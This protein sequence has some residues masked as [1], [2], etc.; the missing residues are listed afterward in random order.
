[1]NI[2][3][4]IIEHKKT[5][6]EFRKSDSPESFLKRESFYSR[7]T[8]SLKS[9]L[10]EGNKWGIIAEFKRK[11]PSKGVINEMADL[12]AVTSAY[13]NHGASGL[14][15]L[16]DEKFFGG[17][18]DDIRKARINSI[19]ILRKDFIIDEYQV[20]ESRAIGADLILLIAACLSPDGV[21]KLAALAKAIG[22]ETLLEIHTKDELSHIC[23]EVDLIGINNRDLKTFA[24]DMN[25]AIELASLVPRNKL[26][27][28]ESGINDIEN[29]RS[30]KNHGFSGFLIGEHFM[31]E[32]DP[33]IA[34]A[35]FINQLNKDPY[36]GKSLRH[37]AT[38]SGQETG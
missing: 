33:S 32:P 17:H 8:I 3:E 36:A 4:T 1:M 34:F 27:I 2:L 23:D 28:A 13:T 19:P 20:H 37:D 16:T 18:L 38:R 9:S 5:E 35:R 14:S 24:V 21:R 31:K 10:M 25:Q 26:L 11:S 15:I 6:I 22:L 12:S 30:L 7:Q 29:I